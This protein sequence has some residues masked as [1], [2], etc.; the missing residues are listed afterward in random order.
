MVVELKICALYKRCRRLDEDCLYSREQ[1]VL[2]V[3]LINELK[4]SEMEED[5]TD[6]PC[7]SDVEV[8]LEVLFQDFPG[9]FEIPGFPPC[10]LQSQV[11]ALVKDNSKVE[12]ELRHLILFN[13]VRS[14][15][16]VVGGVVDSVIVREKDFREY[17]EGLVDKQNELE[18]RAIHYFIDRILKVYRGKFLEE[19]N[20]E[21]HFGKEALEFLPYWVRVGVCVR[22]DN[23]S[24]WLSLPNVG[25]FLKHCLQGRKEI[26]LMLKRT[27]FHEIAV[28]TLEKRK[29]KRSSFPPKF[30]LR[31][32]IGGGQVEQ[33]ESP[34]G[35]MIRLE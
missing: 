17:V 16:V 35:T 15:H 13:A 25:R 9:V 32:L 31:E 8:A 27:R 12:P 6:F 5:T 4:T 18:T 26:L 22:R 23:K 3:L 21:Q 20:L 19:W 24:Y 10:A 1:K 28:K 14:F 34:A 33:I 11:Q 7:P 29:L 2:Q 30:H